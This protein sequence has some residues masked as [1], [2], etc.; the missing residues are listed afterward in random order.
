MTNQKYIPLEFFK[1]LYSEINLD[2]A[3][4]NNEYHK[5]MIVGAYLNEVSPV[6]AEKYSDCFNFDNLCAL[7]DKSIGTNDFLSFTAISKKVLEA[8]NTDIFSKSFS[9]D[10]SYY[11]DGYIR[12]FLSRYHKDDEYTEKAIDILLKLF[13]DHIANEKVYSLFMGIGYESYNSR[14]CLSYEQF[15]YILSKAHKSFQQT[16]GA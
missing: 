15:K 6:I 11:Y 10:K 9:R 16:C 1:D 8:C 7:L 5:S 13:D 12:S 14:P 2:N 4:Y 3:K